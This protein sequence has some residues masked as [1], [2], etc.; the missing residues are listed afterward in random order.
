MGAAGPA[1]G[2]WQA[3]TSDSRWDTPLSSLTPMALLSAQPTLPPQLL[4]G[5]PWGARA[6]SGYSRP[7]GLAGEL[8]EGR[9]KQVQGRIWCPE[10]QQRG[11]EGWAQASSSKPPR[12]LPGV[13]CAVFSALLLPGETLSA[14]RPAEGGLEMGPGRPAASPPGVTDNVEQG[15]EEDTPVQSK[16]PSRLTDGRAQDHQPASCLSKSG[17]A[18][19]K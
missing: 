10:E 1:P 18:A 19:N 8:G 2:I 6:E 5:V 11:S 13:S 14:L 4:S 15:G 12:L 7:H 3:G 16:A 17:P 9:R